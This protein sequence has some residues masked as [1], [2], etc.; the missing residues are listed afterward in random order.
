M[1]STLRTFASLL[2]LVAAALLCAGTALADSLYV[3]VERTSAPGERAVVKVRSDVPGPATLLV[4]RVDDP[5]AFLSLRLDLTKGDVLAA[6]LQGAMDAARKVARNPAPALPDAIP[7]AERTRLGLTPLEVP[8]TFVTTKTADLPKEASEPAGA[9]VDVALPSAGL[10]LIEVR[11]GARSA[12]VSALSSSLA[13]V[14]KR[15][16]TGLLAFAA[17]RVSGGAIEGAAVEVRAGKR[18]L[19]QGRTDAKGLLRLDV[20]APPTVEVRARRGDD[21]AFGVE[22]YVP[23]DVSDRRVYAFPHQPA[24]RPGE[25]V[26]AKGIVRAWRDGH[27]VLDESAREAK[28]AFVAE[29]GRE[30]G[31][32]VAPISADLGTFAAGLDLPADCP[33]GDGTLVIDVGGKSYAAPFRV[34][35]YRKPTFEVRVS[36]APARAMAGQEVAFSCIAS[37]YEGGPVPNAPFGWSLVYTRVDRELF[38]TDELARL[39]FG[40]ERE[41]Y[42]PEVLGV[43]QGTLDAAGR[44]VVKAVLPSKS[45]DGFVS[46]RVTVT[47]PD[48]TAMA[49]SGA[50]ALV[51]AP[52]SVAMKTDKHLYGAEGV[53]QVTVKVALSD[54][55]PAAARAGLLTVAIVGEVAGADGRPVREE[56][57][58]SSH[59]FTTGTDG[60]ARIQV[61]FARN[62]RY[63]LSA[64]VPRVSTEPPGAAARA[65]LHVWVLGDRADEGVSGDRLEV[66]ADKD[67]YA[68]GDVARLLVVSPVG[69]RPFLST[70]EGARILSY[71][72]VRLGG[73]DDRAA[74]AVIEVK[75]GPEHV[76]NLF[77]GVA[78]VDRGN[79]VE[80]T[81]MLRVPP[82]SKILRPVVTVDGGRT[83]AEPGTTVPMSVRVTDASG[84]PAAGVEVAVA[85]VDDALHALYSDPAAPIEP[86][87]HPLRRNDVRTGGPIHATCVG[88]S[89]APRE[90]KKEGRDTTGGPGDAGPP[91]ADAPPPPPGSVPMPSPSAPAPAPEE[92]APADAATAGGGAGGRA[93]ALR[94][95]AGALRD[96]DDSPAKK[97][98]DD[99]G[100]DE[101]P[102]AARADF[103]TTIGWWPAV[104]TGPDGTAPLGPVKLPDDLTRWRMT[105]RAVDAGTRVGTGTSTLRVTKP[106]SARVTL[107][108]FLRV[109]DRVEAPWLLHSLLGIDTT[110]RYVA[111]AT[112]LSLTGPHEGESALPAGA[113]LR[114]ELSLTATGIGE[115]IV[116]AELRTPA[117]NDAVVAKVPVLP[118][119]VPKVLTATAYVESGSVTLAP[120]SRP[121]TAE[122]G[123][124]RLRVTVAPSAAQA[125][126]AA[127]PYLLDYPYGCTEQTMSRLVPVVVAKVAA[128]TW[129]APL[130]GRLADLPKMIDAGLARLRVLQHPDGGFGWWESDASDLYMTAYVAHGLSRAAAVLPDPAPARAIEAKALAW[131]NAY[132]GPGLR[133]EAP[134]APRRL[135]ATRAVG[136]PAAFAWM[137]MA[138]AK[139]LPPGLELPAAWHDGKEQPPTLERAFWLRAALAAGRK[140]DVAMHVQSLLT[141]AVR[142]ANGAHFE[143]G[144]GTAPVRSG[145]WADDAVETTAWSLSAILAA[146]PDHELLAPGARWLLAQR[147]DGA[148]WSST[149]DTA[150]CVGFLTRWAGQR[151]DL[152]VGRPVTVSINGLRLPPL[153]VTPDMGFSETPALDL[154]ETELPEGSITVTAEGP[155]G[156]TVAAALSFTETGPAID[157]ADAGY[158]VE[159]TWWRLVPEQKSGQPVTY[160]RVAFTETVPTGTIVEVEV[161]VSVAKAR[162]LVMVESPHAAGFEPEPDVAL[163]VPG[164]APARKADHT[165]VREDRTV[166]FVTDLPVGTHVFRHRMRAVHLGSFTAL[167]AQ[168]SSMY[169]PWIRGNGRGEVL[170]VARDGDAGGAAGG[171]K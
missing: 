93:P 14:V 117:G 120:L 128:D 37:L 141:H 8:L 86:F 91:T 17:D 147:V 40:T 63:A 114:R 1:R 67:A 158:R 157:P 113:I 142:D 132:F 118:Q 73:A 45:E 155:D 149:R 126:A 130:R 29:G 122:R 94:R 9:S 24:Y 140:D 23:A 89:L 57:E 164:L 80:T 95:A 99:G 59:A 139:T 115:G 7:A 71:D 148:R 100:G 25:R 168:A 167:P 111:G 81:K 19:A 162:D 116:T 35:A 16:P 150:A 165:E 41:A 101:G 135:D 108:R 151:K 152:G 145:R 82:V 105:A 169:A 77:V 38:P 68:V 52:L 170:E 84:A 156:T 30:L 138:E 61:P 32:V 90:R 72:T 119:G 144:D 66:I 42:A 136:A 2:A 127:L 76:P 85:I 134:R 75:V 65:L 121:A 87:F 123:T 49:G 6:R 107:P 18:V 21:L 56:R 44:A 110:A 159:R 78:L 171:G 143:G 109:T 129:K 112:G 131:L 48:R 58:V 60:T 10:Y 98:K 50:V 125:V 54:G 11:R 62:G 4:Y 47:G 137:V 27:H 53:A 31:R 20:A 70:V 43:G 102:L 26:E 88:W 146:A 163:P 33:L 39:F 28:V 51:A 124:A 92:E 97:S 36:G 46:L 160:A 69:G 3:T 83:E 166:F 106:V 154:P 64:A 22:T 79:L 15:D 12:V 74:A 34:Q 161:A 5:A 133:P 13:L 96:G 55:S 153:V 103:R 104:R